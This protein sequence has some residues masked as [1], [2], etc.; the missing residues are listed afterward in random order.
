MSNDV[1]HRN[2]AEKKM[3]RSYVEKKNFEDDSEI[4]EEGS[5]EK[6]K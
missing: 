3:R 1:F 6:G 2:P 5:G 4:V